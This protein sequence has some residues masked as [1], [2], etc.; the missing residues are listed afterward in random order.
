MKFFSKKLLIMSGTAALSFPF[1]AT[2][3]CSKSETKEVQFINDTAL[4]NTIWNYLLEEENS[5]FKIT[6]NDLKNKL[7][8]ELK[9]N[10]DFNYKM[11]IYCFSLLWDAIKNPKNENG[12]ALS[13]N[14]GENISRFSTFLTD[15]VECDNKDE[16]NDDKKTYNNLKK[17]IDTFD[18]S[19]E[20]SFIDNDGNINNN[21]SL[22]DIFD[23]REGIPAQQ[24]GAKLNFWFKFKTSDK[25][26]NEKIF[27]DNKSIMYKNIISRDNLKIINNTQNEELK[28]LLRNQFFYQSTKLYY[29]EGWFKTIILSSIT[30][31][32]D[33]IWTTDNTGWGKNDKKRNLFNFNFESNNSDN[34]S[35]NIYLNMLLSDSNNLSVN[36]ST[37]WKLFL[38]K[39]KLIEDGKFK[40][41]KINLDAKI[42]IEK[43]QN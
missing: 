39:E 8:S 3:S 20:I 30:K 33:T 24:K 15:K 42:N 2:V 41:L 37:N 26:T 40:D 28:S 19:L 9:K 22:L 17:Y 38:T 4:Y 32:G 35:F 16:K 18:W 1:V 43:Q 5:F 13:N 23:S 7:N 14:L 31:Q 27:I 21:I 29:E 12:D 25:E 36:L 6:I 11:K 10:S 34:T